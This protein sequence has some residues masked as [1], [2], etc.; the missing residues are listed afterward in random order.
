[1]ATPQLST[2]ANSGHDLRTTLH[3][4]VAFV[5]SVE[6]NRAMGVVTLKHMV[7]EQLQFL[8]G[9]P[10]KR[11]SRGIIRRS[12]VDS[13]G[14][15]VGNRLSRWDRLDALLAETKKSVQAV[16][17]AGDDASKLAQIGVYEAGNPVGDFPAA[18]PA[19]PRVA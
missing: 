10:Q 4:A 16:R 7:R 5:R 17:S 3:S 11:E 2:G 19:A 12:I 14:A 18:N 15:S 8:G 13:A 6:A 1:M 9:D